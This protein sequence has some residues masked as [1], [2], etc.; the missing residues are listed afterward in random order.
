MIKIIMGV[1]FIA[2]GLSG[3]LV[4]LGTNSGA[5]LA[6]LGVAMVIWGFVQV[7]SRSSWDRK[8]IVPAPL[9]CDSK[10]TADLTVY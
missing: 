2:G 10:M 4:L 7:K 5:A 6:V 9:K 1:V 8:G 3:K